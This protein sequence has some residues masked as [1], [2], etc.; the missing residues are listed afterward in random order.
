M[1]SSVL[2]LMLLAWSATALQGLE[3]RQAKGTGGCA[4]AHIMV[5]R[6]SGEAKGEGMLRSVSSKLKESIKGADSEAIDYPANLAPYGPS[7]SKGVKAANEQLAAYVKRC[8]ESKVVLIG[9][10]QV[11]FSSRRMF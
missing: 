7:E 4:P 10:S 6:A 11:W 9:Y 5:A 8:P 1:R 3:A 2:S